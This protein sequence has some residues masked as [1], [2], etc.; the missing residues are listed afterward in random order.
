MHVSRQQNN[1]SQKTHYK[2]QQDLKRFDF[3]RFEIWGKDLRL[4]FR[5]LLH[6]LGFKDKRFGI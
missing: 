2:I 6:D 3:L 5:I 4:G 1:G